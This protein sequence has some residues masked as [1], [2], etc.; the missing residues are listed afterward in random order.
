MVAFLLFSGINPAIGLV[1]AIILV[2]LFSL[3]FLLFYFIGF[4]AVVNVRREE[5]M[6]STIEENVSE[7]KTVLAYM[8]SAHSS[9]VKS[10]LEENGLKVEREPITGLIRYLN[11]VLVLFLVIAPR[12]ISYFRKGYQKSVI[13]LILVSRPSFLLIGSY[14]IFLK[15]C[16]ESKI[17]SEKLYYAII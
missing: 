16:S 2:G 5:H 12:P 6:A 17:S 4:M 7:G 3:V 14:F 11:L 1:V 13:K 8:G 10:R 9:P 15:C